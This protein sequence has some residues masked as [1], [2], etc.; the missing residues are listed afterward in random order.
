MDLEPFSYIK[1][2]KEVTPNPVPAA[3]LPF[4]EE[5]KSEGKRTRNDHRK[6]KFGNTRKVICPELSSI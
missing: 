3:P 6:E 5:R 4:M 1:G 2:K